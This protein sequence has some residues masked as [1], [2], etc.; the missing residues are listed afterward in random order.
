VFDTI[1]ERVFL[2]RESVYK[3]FVFRVG[4]AD[5]SST[6]TISITKERV[7]KLALS[8]NITQLGAMLEMVDSMRTG[9]VVQYFDN[10]KEDYDPFKD[11]YLDMHRFSTV[12]VKKDVFDGALSTSSNRKLQSSCDSFPNYTATGI[13]CST[14]SHTL[15]AKPLPKRS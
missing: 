4:T 1:V 3:N 7:Q 5:G 8:K 10:Y 15:P 6:T 14:R 11:H 13:V 12:I 9:N 2:E